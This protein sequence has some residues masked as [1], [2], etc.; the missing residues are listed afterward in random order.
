MDNDNIII[1]YVVCGN[2]VKVTAT[3]EITHDEAIIVGD[4]RQNKQV[5]SRLAIK[6]LHTI[7]SKNNKL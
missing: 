6:K 1:E 7:Q 4:V 5:L 2:F 3:D